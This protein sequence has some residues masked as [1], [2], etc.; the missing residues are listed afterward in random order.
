MRRGG[1]GCGSRCGGTS[2]RAG[3]ESAGSAAWTSRAPGGSKATQ[4]DH[5]KMTG[6]AT[7]TR[8]SLEAEPLV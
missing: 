1:G 6:P 7:A 8:L 3:L 4:A 5:G 2:L